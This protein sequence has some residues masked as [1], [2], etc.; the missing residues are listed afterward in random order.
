LKPASAIPFKGP[1][2]IWDRGLFLAPPTIHSR[3]EGALLSV[4][5]K[6]KTNAGA[7]AHADHVDSSHVDSVGRVDSSEYLLLIPSAHSDSFSVA[8]VEPFMPILDEAAA[9]ALPTN[10][11]LSSTAPTASIGRRAVSCVGR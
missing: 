6:R 3:R 5:S 9:T 4:A 11:S 10:V 2:P 8:N 7:L 1:A